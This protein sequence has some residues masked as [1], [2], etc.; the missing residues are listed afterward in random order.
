M[1]KEQFY[2]MIEKIKTIK[3]T[4]ALKNKNEEFYY[5][6]EAIKEGLKHDKI[7]KGAEILYTQRIYV[8]FMSDMIYDQMIHYIKLDPNCHME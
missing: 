8:K 1:E 7:I 2:S 6:I 5:I 4:E 3:Y